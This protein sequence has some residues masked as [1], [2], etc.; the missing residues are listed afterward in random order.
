MLWTVCGIYSNG[1]TKGRRKNTPL[2]INWTIFVTY[3]EWQIKDLFSL[4]LPESSELKKGF[5]NDMGAGEIEI[6]SGMNSH[7]G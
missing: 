1:V 3:L 5:S 7:L 4:H 2:H 6:S